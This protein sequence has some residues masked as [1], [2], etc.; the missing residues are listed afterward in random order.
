MKNATFRQLRFFN[1][2]ARHL[3]FAKA[4]VAMH[5]SA[6]A[7]TM[8][9][10]DLEAEIGMPLFERQGRKV[11]LTTTGEYMLVYSRKML[12]LLKD[13][14]D[15]AARLQRI[16]TGTLT[17]GLVGTTTYFIPALLNQFLKEHEGI[18][19]KLMV[20]NRS[21][22]VQWLQNSEVDIAIMGKAPDELP[23]RAEPFAANPL[24]FVASPEHPLAGEM[25]LRAEDLRQQAF[26]VREPGSGTRSAMESFF[27]QARLQPRYSMELQSNDAIKQAV[28][29]NLGLGFLS[30]HTIALELQTKKL[31]VL[32][33]TGAPLV[34]AWNVVHPLS[35]LL[36][37]AAEAFR[38]FVLEHAETALATRF[39]DLHQLPS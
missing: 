39:A 16:E 37:P 30:L 12:A 15:A 4:A 10:K 5:V 17:I 28:M 24:V 23:T 29:A 26:I 20:G 18:E 22:L 19:L 2:V 14:E 31:C 21:E 1:A 35:K 3:S 11:S 13:A 8:Q 36:S 32:P 33:V 7:V 9:I 6:P 38:Y 25:G 27:T 34:R